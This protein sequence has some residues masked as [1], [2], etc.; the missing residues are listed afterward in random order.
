MSSKRKVL[1]DRYRDNNYL[2][3]EKKR[4]RDRLI[5]EIL[6]RYSI[7]YLIRIYF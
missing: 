5:S 1:D 4:V 2:D 3:S 7:T 6:K